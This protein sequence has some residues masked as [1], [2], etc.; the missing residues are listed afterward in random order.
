[1]LLVNNTN[2]IDSN[3]VF[4]EVQFRL[5]DHAKII[6]LLISQYKNPIQTIVQEYIS[7]AIDATI[8]GGTSEKIIVELPTMLNNYTFSVIDKGIGLSPSRVNDVFTVMGNSTKISSDKQ[9]G[10]FGLGAKSAL[11]YTNSFNI[12]TYYNGNKYLYM[13]HKG[14]SGGLTL[15][16][17][18][19]TKEVGQGTKI[20]IPAKR[21]DSD[22]FREA[23]IRLVSCWDNK[24]LPNCNMDYTAL[25][26]LDISSTVSLVKDHK[27]KGV[28]VL[29]GPVP[30]YIEWHM[31]KNDSASFSKLNGIGTVL[32]KV[33]IGKLMPIQTRESLNMEHDT[34]LANL[35]KILKNALLDITMYYQDLSK[36]GLKSYVKA[37]SDMVEYSRFQPPN[38]KNIQIGTD[39]LYISGLEYSRYGVRCRYRNRK[40]DKVNNRTVNRVNLSDIDG[41]FLNDEGDNAKIKVSRYLNQDKLDRVL[42]VSPTEEVFIAE[43]CPKLLSTL[44]MIDKV[45]GQRKA[46]SQRQSN[47]IVVSMPRFLHSNV[48][49][50]HYRGNI[51]LLALKSKYVYYTNDDISKMNRPLYEFIESKGHTVVNIAKSNI[52]QIK[53]LPQFVTVKSFCDSYKLTKGET[54]EIKYRA[55]ESAGVPISSIGLIHAFMNKNLAKIK[56]SDIKQFLSTLVIPARG[57]TVPT[58]LKVLTND[59][60]NE[61]IELVK[62]CKAFTKMIRD[63][64]SLL[65]SSVMVNCVKTAISDELVFYINAK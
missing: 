22:N 24:D 9:I 33:P 65:E 23:Y 34:T 35:P 11:S 31:L 6:D 43:Y 54:D 51:N 32:I 37:I 41:I 59:Q 45:K 57:E 12:E 26:K 3:V 36:N 21:S 47:T 8:E 28:I 13:V 29:L 52:S 27:H 44:P 5:G 39:C 46:Q 4:N 49:V 16:E 18:L 14:S 15:K 60:N 56:Q 58:E 17:L 42:F 7:N 63:K 64:Y 10:G 53:N 19:V 55:V 25:D 61:I 30:Y 50:N 48:I 62:S 38:Y 2:R 20:S 40:T 1:M